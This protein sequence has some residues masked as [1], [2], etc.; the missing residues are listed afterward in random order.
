MA[1]KDWKYRGKNVWWNNKKQKQLS[2]VGYG[3]RATGGKPSYYKVILMSSKTSKN[4]TP[5]VKR[6]VAIEKT[7]SYMRKN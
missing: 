6:E 2:I 5:L 1:L 4:I 3:F 7:K